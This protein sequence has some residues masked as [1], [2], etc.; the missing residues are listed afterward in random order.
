MTPAISADSARV[1][2]AHVLAEEDARR[3]GDA[4]QR[5]RSAVAEV[6]V[7]QIQLED[8][9]LGRLGLEDQRHELSSGL[10]RNDRWRGLLF[11]GHFLG[12]EE[13]AGQLL[14]DRAARPPD[15]GGCR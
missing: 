12:Q 6:D 4:V 15:S 1:E 10:R 14:G 2:V 13:H 8:L 3:F 9:V 7:V 5:K 11:L